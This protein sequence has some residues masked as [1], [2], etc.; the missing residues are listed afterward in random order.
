MLMFLNQVPPFRLNIENRWVVMILNIGP[1]DLLVKLNCTGLCMSD[2]HYMLKD[3]PLRVQMDETGVRSPG[4]EGAGVVVEVGS[5]VTDWKIGDRAGIKPMM[6]TCHNCEL[7]WNGIEYVNRWVEGYLY[8]QAT[9][10]KERK[11]RSEQ[12]PG[13]AA[14]ELSFCLGCRLPVATWSSGRVSVSTQPVLLSKHLLT[15][16]P[17]CL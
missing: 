4:H 3:L 2:V 13:S 6:D 17:F 15:F 10:W 16:L 11:S 8:H 7:C 5:N 1:N 12:S 9:S 14:S